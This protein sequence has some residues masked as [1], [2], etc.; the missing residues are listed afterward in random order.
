MNIFVN[1]VLYISALIF[2]GC[3]FV[4]IFKVAFVFF[5]PFIL[6]YI[7]SKLMNPLKNICVKK[8]HIPNRLAS[9]ITMLI[10]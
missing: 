10:I 2:I 9:F 8:F 3:L 1:K 4:Y 6:A 5:L 7:I